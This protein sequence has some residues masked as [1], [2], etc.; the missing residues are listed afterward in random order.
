MIVA[1]MA[2]SSRAA[3]KLSYHFLY[4]SFFFGEIQG[5]RAP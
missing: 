2:L 3:K 1:V 4:H 5:L